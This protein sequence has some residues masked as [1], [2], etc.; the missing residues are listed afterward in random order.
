MNT[1]V[2]YQSGTDNVRQILAWVA[3]AFVDENEAVSVE[4]FH[5]DEIESPIPPGKAV[6]VTFELVDHVTC[7][8][9]GG[10]LPL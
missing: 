9:C 5:G 3:A 10:D 7:A 8:T 6:K 1:N 2:K 4:I